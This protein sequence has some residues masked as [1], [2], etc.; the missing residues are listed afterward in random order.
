MEQRNARKEN[1]LLGEKHG[2]YIARILRPIK[3]ISQGSL[4]F[5][6]GLN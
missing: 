3:Q 2:K 5:R 6:F 1:S 4:L